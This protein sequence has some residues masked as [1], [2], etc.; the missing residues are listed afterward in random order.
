MSSDE[1][2]PEYAVSKPMPAA[3]AAVHANA[4]RR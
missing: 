1:D 2:Q 3:M 4:G